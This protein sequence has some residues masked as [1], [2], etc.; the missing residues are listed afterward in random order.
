LVANVNQNGFTIPKINVDDIVID[1]NSI[2]NTASNTLS[3]QTTGNVTINNFSLSGTTITNTVNNSITSFVT[4]G[5]GYF[6]V[7]GTGAMV[8]PSGVSIDRPGNAVVVMMRFDTINNRLEVYDGLN[9]IS[10]AGS[11]VGITR[12]EAEDIAVGIALIFG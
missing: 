11:A 5:T 4:T 1:N 10:A 8:I 12:P 9:W 2:S 7:P 3:I 6:S